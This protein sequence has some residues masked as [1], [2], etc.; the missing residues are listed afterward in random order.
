MANSFTVADSNSK[1]SQN[2]LLIYEI[3]VRYK[4]SLLENVKHW[5]V[6]EHD[7]YIRH[8]MEVIGEF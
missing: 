5:Q 1:T 7:E 4:P 3:E 6:F 8:F 2:P